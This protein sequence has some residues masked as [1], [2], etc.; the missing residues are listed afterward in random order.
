VIIYDSVF[1]MFFCKPV[2]VVEG[3]SLRTSSCFDGGIRNV[4][5]GC[6]LFSS[7]SISGFIAYNTCVG[8]D[9]VEMN[10]RW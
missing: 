6:D 4:R 8:F 10:G 3:I 1:F 7:K 2:N 9:F 5:V